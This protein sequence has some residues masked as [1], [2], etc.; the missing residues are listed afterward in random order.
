[1]KPEGKKQQDDKRPRGGSSAP[2][3]NDPSD[4]PLTEDEKLDEAIRESFGASD[5]PA[6]G[7]TTGVGAPEK[8]RQT[9]RPTDAKT[10]KQN[11]KT[12]K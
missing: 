6:H 3:K 8:R 5:P 12:N 10:A 9:G 11:N 2:P 7:G 1:M 4:R